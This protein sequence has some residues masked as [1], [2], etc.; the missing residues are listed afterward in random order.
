M[1][2]YTTAGVALAALLLVPLAAPAQQSIADFVKRPT[3]GTAKISPNGDYLAITVDHGEQDVLTVLDAASLK[4]LKVNVLPDRKSVGAFYWTGAKRLMFNAVRKNGSIERPRG[5]GEW[6]AVDADGSYPRTL[7]EYGDRDATQRNK[8][9]GAQS[10][11]LLDDLPD[12]DVNV[13]MQA[14]YQ[15]SAT[16]SGAEVV[17]M[18]TVSGRR[19][20]LGRAPADNCSIVLTAAKQPGWAVCSSDEDDATG[21]DFHTSVYQRDAGGDW[22]LLNSS[23]TGGDRLRVIG[24]SNDGRIYAMQGDG[25]KPDA[26]GTLDPATGKFSELFRD[27]VS[28]VSNYIVSVDGSDRVIAVATEA[29]APRVTLIEEEHPDTDLF[30]QLA[31]A[32]PG[33]F[34]NFGSATRDGRKVVVNV[35]SDQNPGD[36]YLYDRDTG[37]ARFLLKRRPWLD[38]ARMASKKSVAFTARD[39]TRIHGYLT[40]PHGSDGKNLPLIVNVHGGPMGPRDDWAF[41]MEPQLFASRGYATLQLNYRGSGGFGKAFQDMAYG[42]WAT[43]I[44]NDIIDGTNHVVKEGYAD[45][46][47]ICIYGAS[48]GGYASLMAPVRDPGMFK[49]AFGYVG[50]YDAQIQLTQS[51]TAQSASGKRYLMRAFGETRAEQDAMSPITF[52]DQIKL[53]VYL[54]AGARDQRTPPAHTEAMAKALTAAGNPP[55]GMIIKDG[56]EHGYYKEENNLELYTKMLEFF[57]RHIGGGRSAAR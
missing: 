14:R 47:R 57:A 4:P 15:R 22:T 16:G 26:F 9:V 50:V 3:Y 49:C 2:K 11:S 24:S 1:T 41:S 13:L 30:L 17:L 43:G 39:G 51:D 10:F 38:P 54:A 37:K 23:K 21:F 33:Q 31:E 19:K 12:D 27:P 7:I 5:T 6:F 18:D 44:M 42:Q 35:Y 36:L 34:I 8:A 48:F 25:K 28:D 32:F 29:G 55:E 45:K 20:S 40:I 53:P 56:E 46:D 52:A